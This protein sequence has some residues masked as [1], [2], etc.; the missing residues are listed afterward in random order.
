MDIS[1]AAQAA[2]TVI[3]DVMKVEPTVATMAGM[4]VPGAAPIVAAVQPMVMM[5]APF[6][7]RAIASIA[8]KNG[9]DAFSALLDLLN[10]ISPGRPNSPILA[11]NYAPGTDPS[12]QGNA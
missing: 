6:I 10:H 11:P 7:E 3:E 5:A 12:S 8:A 9:G 1:Q 4:F 2:E